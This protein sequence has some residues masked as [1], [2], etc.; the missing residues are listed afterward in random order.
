MNF[1]K[2]F[3]IK[4]KN[5]ILKLFKKK[6]IVSSDPEKKKNQDKTDDIYPLW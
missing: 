2:D 6:E 4:L 3:I 5:L 1:F